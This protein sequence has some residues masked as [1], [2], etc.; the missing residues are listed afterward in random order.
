VEKHGCIY[1]GEIS[2]NQQL[3]SKPEGN[4]K[5]KRFIII[6]TIATEI[7]VIFLSKESICKSN[8]YLC[9]IFSNCSLDVL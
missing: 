7:N 9:S 1:T 8:K 3:I 6:L 5:T 4:H 2:V